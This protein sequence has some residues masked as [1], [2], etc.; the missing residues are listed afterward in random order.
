MHE[1]IIEVLLVELFKRRLRRTASVSSVSAVKGVECHNHVYKHEC[2]ADDGKRIAKLPWNFVDEF[3]KWLHQKFDPDK[4]N[5]PSNNKEANT[6][7][8]IDVKRQVRVISRANSKASLKIEAYEEFEKPT[9][10]CTNDEN[11]NEIFIVKLIQN[12]G[13]NTGTKSINW[14]EWPEEKAC[15]LFVDSRIIYCHVPNNFSEV[16][17]NT[18]NTEEPKEIKEVKLRTAI[19]VKTKVS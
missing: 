4:P 15:A 2:S 10:K 14:A 12:Y 5:D 7:T 17:H 18:H 13:D 11:Y 3:Y 16:A 19:G 1:V 8:A 9:K 6:Y